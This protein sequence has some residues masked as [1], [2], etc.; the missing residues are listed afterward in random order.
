ARALIAL[1]ARARR[2][3]RLRSGPP[4]LL[5]MLKSEPV[6]KKRCR[7]PASTAARALSK[8]VTP[9]ARSFGASS[10][11]GTWGAGGVVSGAL[12]G[13]VVVEEDGAEE[14]TEPSSPAEQPAARLSPATRTAALMGRAVRL[15]ERGRRESR[16][17]IIPTY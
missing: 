4:W 6:P 15:R 12:A 7:T 17:V 5:S 16:E 10:S 3:A 13:D 14:G 2:A 8:S 9:T 11:A 1:P